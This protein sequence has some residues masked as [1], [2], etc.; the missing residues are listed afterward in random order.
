MLE[1]IVDSIIRAYIQVLGQE[2]WD[3]LS[4]EEQHDALMIL[5][6]DLLKARVRSKG[7]R[8]ANIMTLR[9]VLKIIA[10]PRYN[11]DVFNKDGYQETIRVDFIEDKGIMEQIK[12]EK[13]PNKVANIRV[14]S[15]TGEL[16][17]IVDLL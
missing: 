4:A 15:K 3:S 14:N 13:H 16:H 2:K 11:I 10:M 6:K 5:V 7:I 1:F 9:S 12:L 8:R 17:V